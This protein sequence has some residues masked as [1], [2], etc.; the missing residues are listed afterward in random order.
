MPPFCSSDTWATCILPAYTDSSLYQETHLALCNNV[1]HV[2]DEVMRS[3]HCFE[4]QISRVE[5]V[6][7]AGAC[8]HLLGQTSL[9]VL[10]DPQQWPLHNSIATSPGRTSALAPAGSGLLWAPLAGRRTY[11]GPEAKEQLSL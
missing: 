5:F 2:C 11:A 3:N 8:A 10:A 7:L 9:M 1:L 6:A 4:T